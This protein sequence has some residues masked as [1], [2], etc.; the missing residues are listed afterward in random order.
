MVCGCRFMEKCLECWRIRGVNRGGESRGVCVIVC[1]GVCVKVS[2]RRGVCVCVGG[3]MCASV[4][5]YVY[6]RIEC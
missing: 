4:C 3:C 2:V 1:V 6:V 5:R